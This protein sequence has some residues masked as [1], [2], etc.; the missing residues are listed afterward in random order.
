[1]EKS[2]KVRRRY[3]HPE[4]VA[5]GGLKAKVPKFKPML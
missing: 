5:A 3:N 4:L 1:M 2:V